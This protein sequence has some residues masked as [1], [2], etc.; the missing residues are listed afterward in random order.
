MPRFMFWI[1]LI[2]ALIGTG[3]AWGTYY[4]WSISEDLVANGLHARGTVI[5]LA[6]RR[7][8]DGGGTYVPVVEFL[9]SAGE[10]RIYHS[11]SGSNPPAYDRGERVDLYYDRENPERAMIDSF[12][13]RWMLPLI[14]GVMATVFGAA[15]YT[16][17]FFMIRRWWRVRWLK[18][19]GGAVEA[20]FVRCVLDT[21]TTVNGMHPWR[22]EASGYHP[23]TR[24]KERF[25]SDQIWSNLDEELQGKTVRVRIDPRSTRFHYVDLSRYL[26]EN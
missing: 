24:R 3:L 19:H 8:D 20:D 7:D 2:F 21:S 17:L 10:T 11:T 26:G 13:D 23:A 22:V 9:D 18:A 15:G 12:T 14:L 1:G 16:V 25:V 5:D 4:A 6:Y